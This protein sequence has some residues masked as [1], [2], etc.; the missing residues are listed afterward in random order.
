MLQASDFWLGSGLARIGY[1]KSNT[2]STGPI[3]G[4]HAL[5]LN[6][7]K[8]MIQ[9]ITTRTRRRKVTVACTAIENGSLNSRL[10]Y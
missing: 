3:V 7:G 6:V 4:D 5:N 2:L 8:A 1:G 10:V 9:Q